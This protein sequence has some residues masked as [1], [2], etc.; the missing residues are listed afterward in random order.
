M[1]QILK[2]RIASEMT[3]RQNLQTNLLEIMEAQTGERR[4]RQK[5]GK[6]IQEKRYDSCAVERQRDNN[7]SNKYFCID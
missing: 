1:Q 6:L 4:A 2:I 5:P 3:R 7:S